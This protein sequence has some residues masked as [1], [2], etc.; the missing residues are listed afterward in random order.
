MHAVKPDMASRSWITRSGQA[1]KLAVFYLLISTTVFLF[2]A[3]VMAV[4]NVE[5]LGLLSS[6]EFAFA[7]VG[8]GFASLIW[9]CSSVRCPR[10]GH[11]P[12]WGILRHSAASTWLVTLHTLERC[13]RCTN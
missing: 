7:F 13:P 5:V 10:C 2:L 4:N 3:F 9:I 1:W 6:M 12:V 11:R 8:V